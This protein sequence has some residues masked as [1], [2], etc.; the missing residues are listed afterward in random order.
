[1]TGRDAAA[2]S[3]QLL[4]GKPLS[5]FPRENQ[6][7]FGSLA[8]HAQGLLFSAK[9]PESIIAPPVTANNRIIWHF[10]RTVASIRLAPLKAP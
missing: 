4:I 7:L 5:R 8:G 6:R 9:L 2:P 10:I 1:M 3:A